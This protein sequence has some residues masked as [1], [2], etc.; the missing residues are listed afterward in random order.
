MG[1]LDS[2]TF[3]SLLS[4]SS[5]VGF[6]LFTLQFFLPAKQLCFFAHQKAI[7]KLKSA[8]N[9]VLFEIFNRKNLTK[10]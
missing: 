9:Q 1:S 3:F 7:L 6:L 5:S 8:K 10:I 2:Q 4:S